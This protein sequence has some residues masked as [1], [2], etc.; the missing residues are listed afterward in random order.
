M[1]ELPEVETIKN[2]LNQKIKGRKI[3][4]ILYSDWQKGLGGITREKFEKAVKGRTIIGASRR[5]KNI[6]LELSSGIYIVFHMKMSGHLLVESS[7]LKVEN[8]R[9]TGKSLSKELRDSKNQFVHL[10]ILLSGGLQMAMSDLRKFGWAKIMDKK[11]LDQYLDQYGPEPLTS[12]FTEKKLTEILKDKKGPIKKILMDQSAIA[13]IGNIYSDEILF[14]AGIAPLRPASKI[15]KKEIPILYKAIKNILKKAIKLRG[16]SSEDFRDTSGKLGKYGDLKLVYQ[17]EK[18][19]CKKCKALI[20]RIK[21][22]GRS[23]HY[24]PRCQK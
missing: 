6:I 17:R 10:S 12:G 13:G 14:T 1:P 24:C 20:K 8:G 9:W 18:E 19:K 5:A 7:K 4:G 2:D 23:A 21:I 11:E 22:G 16:T 3:L 15:T